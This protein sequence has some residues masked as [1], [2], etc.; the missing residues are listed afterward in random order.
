M[1][2]R[3]RTGIRE[4]AIATIASAVL[5]IAWSTSALADKAAIRGIGEFTV[6]AWFKNSFLD[7]REDAAEAGARRKHL[8][9]YVGQDGCPYCA[10]LFNANFSQKHIVEYTRAHFDALEINLWGDRPVT[11]FDGETLTEKTFAAKHDVRFTPTLLFFDAQGTKLLR[12]NGYYSPRR[13]IAALR[14]VAEDGATGEPFSAYLA[15]VAPQTAPS[16]LRDEP[17]FSKPP[18]DL[19]AGAGALPIVV[20]F[21]QRD[22]DECDELHRNVFAQ[23]ETREQLARFRVIQLD[24]WSATPLTTP[25]GEQSTAR[26][27]ADQ[28]GVGYVPAAIFFDQG[29]EVMRIDAMLKAFH[30]QSVMDYVASGAYRAQP[31]F[32]RFIQSRAERLRER[33]IAVDLWK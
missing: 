2:L 25:D 9:V 3:S 1:S 33:G 21:E 8:L 7:L 12:I 30:V 10:A 24:R 20:F 14:Y 5:A 4:V 19:R 13:F 31:T 29:R 16:A 26:A 27:W 11:D 32:Q 18:H 17:F 15:R 23:P 28:L 22:C 6:P